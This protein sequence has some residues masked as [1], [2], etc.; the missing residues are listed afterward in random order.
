MPWG[1]NGNRVGI[2]PEIAD[3]LLTQYRV[4]VALTYFPSAPFHDTFDDS[5][6]SQDKYVFTFNRPAATVIVNDIP[7]VA[8]SVWFQIAP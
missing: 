7:R 2:Y 1:G 8:A 6:R 4:D 3:Y 5:Q